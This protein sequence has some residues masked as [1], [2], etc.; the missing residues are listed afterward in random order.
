MPYHV[1]WRVRRR[2]G[3]LLY[4][5]W[6][7]RCGG[8]GLAAGGSEARKDRG[9]CH[10]GCGGER[11]V[12]ST[13]LMEEVPKVGGSGGQVRTR[14]CSRVMGYHDLAHQEKIGWIDIE[15]RRELSSSEAACAPATPRVRHA[16]W[17]LRMSGSDR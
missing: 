11:E 7:V 6:C 15:D 9:S 5:S 14:G 8:K 13:C 10:D 4:L 16:N 12:R 2:V 1:A 3:D 17:V